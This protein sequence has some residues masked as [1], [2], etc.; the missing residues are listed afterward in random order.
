MRNRTVLLAIFAGLLLAP[1]QGA[2]AFG[3]GGGLSSLKRQLE[4]RFISSRGPTLAPMGHVIFCAKEPSQCRSFGRS[5]VAM[6]AVK[7]QELNR[8]NA[9]VNHSIR[10]V[11]DRGSKGW[12]D[13]WTVAP[14]SGDCEDFA[15]TKRAELIARGWPSRA[16][17]IAVAKTSWGEGHAVLVVRTTDGD[18]VL[19]NRRSGVVPWHKSGLTWLK[20]QSPDDAKRWLAL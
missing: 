5:V 1:V 8:I 11:N 16:L 20:I 18:L 15:L 6:N 9:T 14:K 19:D 7:K 2:F 12:A 13:T 4:P 10:P 3:L 17:R